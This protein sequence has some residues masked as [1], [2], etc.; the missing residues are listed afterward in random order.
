MIYFIINNKLK[1]AF[2]Y[3]TYIKFKNPS[4]K[5]FSL[6]CEHFI[7]FVTGEIPC[8]IRYSMSCREHQG[9]REELDRLDA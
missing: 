4:S 5:S 2:E 1:E 3:E 7:L 8:V 6:E 9:L